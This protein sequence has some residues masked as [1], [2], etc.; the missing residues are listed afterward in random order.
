MTAKW[1]QRLREIGE[2]KASAG[3]FM[4]AVKK[5]SA[6]IISDAVESSES[7]DFQ[8]LDIES[9]QRSGPKRGV[10]HP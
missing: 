1:E 8:G 9:I 4:E 5:M 3:A 10:R 7:W 2:G 6:K